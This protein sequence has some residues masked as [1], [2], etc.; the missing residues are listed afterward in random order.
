MVEPRPRKY[1]KLNEFG[2][3]IL[4]ELKES[5]YKNFDVID[6]LLKEEL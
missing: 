6:T 2:T 1:Y 5:Y 4:E 3:E